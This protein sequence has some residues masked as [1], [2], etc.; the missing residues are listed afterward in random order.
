MYAFGKELIQGHIDL[1]LLQII[2]HN[3]IYEQICAFANTP[4]FNQVKGKGKIVTK[5][6]IEKCHRDKKRF[7][8]RRFALDSK[9]KKK[10]ESEDEIWDEKLI[11]KPETKETP[12]K[13]QTEPDDYEMDTDDEI[14]AM[15][16]ENEEND[17]KPKAN[18][19]DDDD[20]DDAYDAETDVD[21][22]DNEL[23]QSIVDLD[24]PELPDFFHKKVFFLYGSFSDLK[25]KH[26]KRCIIAAG[27]QESQYMNSKVDL[28]ITDEKWNKDFDGALKDHPKV[29]FVTSDYV[30]GCWKEQKYLNYADFRVKK[31]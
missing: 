17:E 1:G 14:E 16:K 3:L 29:K 21:D 27:G 10:D 19:G 15:N 12:K 24:F 26:I 7:P 30:D 5:D 22:D 4:K 28:I 18:D 13:K 8:W 6:W 9:D 25:R 31:R 23:S 20:D 11:P 2:I